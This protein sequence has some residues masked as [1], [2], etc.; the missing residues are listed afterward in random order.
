MTIRD[1]ELIW[2]WRVLLPSLLL[3]YCVCLIRVVLHAGGV[4]DAPHGVA[5]VVQRALEGHL[6]AG[7]VVMLQFA[8]GV[9]A[10]RAIGQRVDDLEATLF[11]LVIGFGGFDV[12][13]WIL[14][15]LGRL[16]ASHI[17]TAS[18]IAASGGGTLK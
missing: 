18:S 6:A 5:L 13:A 12:V 7:V 14:A 3:F 2:L 9:T 10:L 1:V 16:D 17:G 8:I 15:L 4:V 11:A